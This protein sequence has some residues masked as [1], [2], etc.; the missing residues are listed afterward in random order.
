[1]TP[2]RCSLMMDDVSHTAFILAWDGKAEAFGNLPV[3]LL[4]GLFQIR[5][6]ELPAGGDAVPMQPVTRLLVVE[7]HQF[8]ESADA[9]LRIDKITDKQPF[10]DRLFHLF[11]LATVCQLV[12]YHD[13]HPD[14]S[15][16]GVP[17]FGGGHVIGKF[18][19]IISKNG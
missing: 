17:F 8:R 4:L 18:T 13:L 19:L 1:M 12:R 3:I 16:A 10:A 9:D 6:G 11:L 7:L 2:P 5:I 14:F 15:L